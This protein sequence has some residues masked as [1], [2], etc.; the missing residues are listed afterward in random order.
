[1]GHWTAGVIFM[2]NDPPNL[3]LHVVRGKQYSQ[4][5]LFR[6]RLFAKLSKNHD[7]KISDLLQSPVQTVSCDT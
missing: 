2:Q 3:D 4:N 1:M 5:R 6:H 7:L